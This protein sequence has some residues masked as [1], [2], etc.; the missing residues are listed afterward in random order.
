MERND[1]LRLPQT[2][3]DIATLVTS[4]R[5]EQ[6]NYVETASNTQILLERGLSKA[7]EAHSILYH[8][9][10]EPAFTSAPDKVFSTFE[11]TE[12]ILL[13]LPADDLILATQVCRYWR[14]VIERSMPAQKVVALT[15]PPQMSYIL[16]R[17]G[18]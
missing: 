9:G 15:N 5:S 16:N 3:H 8:V 2:R 17:S 12:A 18:Q 14:G 13:Q 6:P 11:L 1:A 4:F 10:H 7:S